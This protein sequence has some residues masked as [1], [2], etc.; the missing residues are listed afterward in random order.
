M[1]VRVGSM[2]AAAAHAGA[3][4]SI[5]CC[6]ACTRACSS[7]PLAKTGPKQ[8]DLWSRGS[9]LSMSPAPTLGKAAGLPQN[10]AS[11]NPSIHVHFYR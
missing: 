5:T 2:S 10:S 1:N 4:D 9:K 6:S 7:N 3:F 8:L 11:L